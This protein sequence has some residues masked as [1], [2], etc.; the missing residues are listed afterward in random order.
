MVC[1]TL[2]SDTTAQISCG[3]K[4]T[5]QIRSQTATKT[6]TVRLASVLTVEY[7]CRI[8]IFHWTVTPAYFI[9]TKQI[10]LS[11]V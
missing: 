1:L 4:F 5:L 10:L 8:T 7:N 11:F 3:R 9:Q 6:P 2:K